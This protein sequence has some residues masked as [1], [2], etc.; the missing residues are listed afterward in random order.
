MSIP[1]PKSHCTDY[2]SLIIILEVMFTAFPHFIIL[3]QNRLA[4]PV[5]LPSYINFRIIPSQYYEISLNRHFVN[6]Y[7]NLRRNN[8]IY[9]IKGSNP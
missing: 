4:L 5:P 2:C 1:L 3:S 8:M 7:I 9:C 6:L